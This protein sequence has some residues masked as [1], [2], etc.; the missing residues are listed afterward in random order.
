[1]YGKNIVICDGEKQY[2]NNLLRVFA[3]RREPGVQLHL[4]YNL[5][6][7]QK[8][9]AQKTIHIL[10]IAAEYS[11]KDRQEIQAESCYVLTR[12]SEADTGGDPGILR[13]QSAANI[14]AQ[15]VQEV[16]ERER[17]TALA[18][19]RTKGALIGVYSPVHRIGKTRFAL[20]MG[21][22]LAEKEPVLYLNMEEYPGENQIF[23]EETEGHL[24]DLLMYQKQERKNLGI[25]I[26]TM[27]G[28]VERLDYIA[29]IPYLQDLK[30]VPGKEWLELLGRI[31]RECIYAKVI[32]DLGDSVDG[33][34]EILQTCDVIY[35]PY[36]EEPISRAKLIQYTENLRKTGLEDI[37]E[38]TIQKRLRRK[39][40]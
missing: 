3:A 1:M 25:R 38:K 4:F 8:F 39:T 17:E 24:G 11:K 18:A 16:P 33:L 28:Q 2:A 37:L 15:M 35:T 20:G 12:D 19:V 26:S 40:G 10:L 30:G 13:Y 36:I 21:K 14:W 22:K 31:R 29:P 6:E 23:Q 32:L 7:L 34:F 27:A 5:S 9:A